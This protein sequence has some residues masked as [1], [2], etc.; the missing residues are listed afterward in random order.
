M[1]K[2]ISRKRNNFRSCLAQ[3]FVAIAVFSIFI[4]IGC[5]GGSDGDKQQV[6]PITPPPPPPPPALRAE[7]VAAASDYREPIILDS[8]VEGDRNFYVIYAGHIRNSLISQLGPV[9]YPGVGTIRIESSE[10]FT[11]SMQRSTTETV[12]SSIV[13]T[14]GTTNT[15]S[16][17]TAVSMGLEVGYDNKFVAKF[18]LETTITGRSEVSRTVEVGHGRSK[19][20]S[21]TT[22]EGLE[23]AWTNST[24][25]EASSGDPVGSYRVAWYTVNDVYFVIS[26]SLD[27]QN[28]LTW[29]VV[30]SSRNEQPRMA[31]E[32]SANGIFDNSPIQGSEI[33]FADGFYKNLPMPT[34]PQRYNLRV[35]AG[36]GGT[37][38]HASLTTYDVGTQVTVTATSD[39]GHV[40]DGWTGVPTGV[41]ASNAS[42][43]FTINDNL[44]LTASFRMTERKIITE[45][46]TSS[47]NWSLPAE[48]TFPATI[49]VFLFG[50]GGGGQG[51]HAHTFSDTDGNG[52]S[53]GSGAAVYIKFVAEDAVDFTGITV[54]TGG[55]GTS[56][57][58][59]GMG[60]WRSANAGV[61]GQGTSI[62]INN[63]NIVAG[64][65]IGGGSDGGSQSVNG[66]NGGTPNPANRPTITGATIL[67]YNPV[68][69]NTGI[70]GAR[71]A[72]RGQD[73]GVALLLGAYSSGEGGASGRGCFA[74]QGGGGI[75]GGN[76]MIVIVV[77][78][79]E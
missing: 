31:F 17:E 26:T 65:G 16:I 70:T 3:L 47:R 71:V 49:E 2:S 75:R 20:T 58:L 38:S 24:S 52:G 33:R 12:S 32:F 4:I 43:T 1:T 19:E 42:I 61:N 68:H 30:S 53:G 8:W 66:G 64:G 27:R 5:G 56:C 11:E 63:T 41:N 35:S 9:D 77:E 67:E 14:D 45:T 34:T 73:G 29:D 22:I 72:P 15:H 51:G 79:F 62:R 54:G 13:V 59:Q 78:Y 6:N 76:G 37:V 25:M 28:L 40:F 7:P 69:G 60:S 57:H 10:T 21:E 36:S 46:F 74:G 48:V 50:A 18:S 39:A 55:G 23:R 44:T